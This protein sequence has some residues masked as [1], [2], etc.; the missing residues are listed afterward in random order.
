[1]E[2]LT[3]SY[4]AEL[5][6]RGIT[7]NAIAPGLTETDMLAAGFTPELLAILVKNTPLR[8]LGLPVDIARVASFLA[9]DEAGWITGQVIAAGGGLR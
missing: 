9:S 5:G 6:P 4:A 2:A 8:R 7:V 1:M 3:R